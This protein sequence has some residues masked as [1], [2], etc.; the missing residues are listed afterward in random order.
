MLQTGAAMHTSE[1]DPDGSFPWLAWSICLPLLLLFMGSAT[2]WRTQESRVLETAREMVEGSSPWLTPQCNGELRL[3]KPPLAYW[4]TAGAFKI[5]GINEWAG[6]APAVLVTWLTIGLCG[7]MASTLF[8][9]RAGLLS[10]VLMTATYGA[11]RFGRLAETDTI[12]MLGVTLGVWGFWRASETN[13]NR[14]VTLW[15]WAAAIGMSI[16]AMGKGAPAAFP[17]L[18]LVTWCIINRTARPLWTFVRSGGILI[19]PIF[20]LGWYGYIYIWEFGGLSVVE[21]EMG[22]VLSG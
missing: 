14:E 9:R 8:G 16:A 11:F 17:L 19:F 3:Q 5:G 2:A 4:M 6:R 1:K 10:I 7:H 18:F 22:V 15:N 12:A 20:G 21:K 13:S